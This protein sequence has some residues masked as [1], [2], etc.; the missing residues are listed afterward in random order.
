MQV[1]YLTAIVTATQHMQ[2][3][4]IRITSFYP[5]FFYFFI[6]TPFN[7][8]ENRNL[9]YIHGKTQLSIDTVKIAFF[10]LTFYN[11]T[12]THIT[13]K[14]CCVRYFGPT[15]SDMSHCC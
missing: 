15:A 11:Q 9:I 8:Q 2:S 10:F 12:C 14:N 6:S 1:T 13:G 5:V 4:L 7:Q 3:S